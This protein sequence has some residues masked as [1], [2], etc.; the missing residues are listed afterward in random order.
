MAQQP[1]HTAAPWRYVV[2][3]TVLC[4][5]FAVLLGQLLWLQLVRG[6]E[7]RRQADRQRLRMVW[8]PALRGRIY[9]RNLFPLAANRPSFDID[10]NVDDMSGRELTNAVKRLA[11]LLETPLDT[12]WAALA[13]HKR[14][15]FMPARVADDVPFE[16]MT[17][18]AEHLTDMPDGVAINAN[19][20]RDYA[21]HT[22]A[23]HVVG[24]VGMISSNHPRLLS[25]EYSLNDVV[26]KSGVER[27]CEEAL[28]GVNGQRIVQVDHAARYFSTIDEQLATPGQDVVLTLDLTLQHTLERAFS[29]RVGAA[30]ALDPRNGEV[31]ALVSAPGFD[32]NVF[33]GGS[34]RTGFAALL[35]DMNKPLFNRALAGQYP[36]GSVFKLITTIASVE[37]G[38]L[39]GT[40]MFT[41]TG[42]FELGTMHVQN[43]HKRRYGTLNLINALRYSCNTF[44]CTFGLQVGVHQLAAYGRM[45][46]FG[47]ITGIELPGE[48]PGI[49]PDPAWKR[50]FRHLPWYPGDTVNLS[51]GHGFLLVTPLQVAC[52]T[53]AI[54]NGG[55][56]LPPHV[57]RGYSA[58]GTT[59]R[60]A[61]ETPPM[62]LP[63][64]PATLDLVREGMWQVVNTPDGSGRNAYVPTVVVAGKTG[65]AM[66][67]PETYA[68][69][70]AFAPFAQPRF[71][72]AIVVEHAQTGGKDA[73]PIAQQAIA[74]YFDLDLAALTNAP[75][76]EH[77]IID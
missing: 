61:Q 49:L 73:A 72:I 56:L 35:A 54:A 37:S 77:T 28:H 62:P 14:F 33:A 2:L 16:R 23:A 34:S 39:S 26:G 15:S 64:K 45:L 29:N 20:A 7:F 8:L 53:A 18:I 47:Q 13:P 68:W 27:V 30:V 63:I 52:M 41:D 5:C 1:S 42:S 60:P 70:V 25:G 9:D 57:I 51:I 58:G 4:C 21:L 48:L 55:L 44:F 65:S 76:G 6:H 19:P 10:I 12:L 71:V 69:F 11:V 32:P 46:G 36:L 17:H 66:L 43:F 31:L 67:G 3:I 22:I 74:S 75:A 38:I 50:R 40:T 59:F 24:Y